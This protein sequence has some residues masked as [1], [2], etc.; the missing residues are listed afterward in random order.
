MKPA[1][2]PYAYGAI[3]LRLLAEGDL[4][5]TLAWRNRDG[6]RQQF[7]SPALVEWDAHLSWFERYLQK[8]D[9]L[10]FV[11]ELAD[12]GGKVGQVAIYAI[13]DA[14]RSAELGRFVAAPEFQGRGL[15]RE[16]IEVLMRFAASRLEL[17]S[18]YL[19]VIETNER[20]RRLYESL[21]FAETQSV[22][23]LIRMERSI[24]DYL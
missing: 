21:G 19:E 1:H 6:V 4:R 8:S 15:M 5:E 12:T 17:A 3:R 13:D 20:A 23:V 16:A 22:D 24:D 14:T 9:D 18:V 10:V 2:A 11:A 7:K